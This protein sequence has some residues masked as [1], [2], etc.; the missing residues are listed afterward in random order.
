MDVPRLFRSEGHSQGSRS[1]QIILPAKYARGL[2]SIGP[3]IFSNAP[4][5]EQTDLWRP[6]NT[7]ERSRAQQLQ[8]VV[9]ELDKAVRQWEASPD[10]ATDVEQV[11][12]RFYA[13]RD[14]EATSAFD[15]PDE[16]RGGSQ[17][18]GGSFTI[19][20]GSSQRSWE[21][22]S[23]Q[24]ITQ[25][26]SS[27][28]A[29]QTD[30]IVSDP[31]PALSI[32]H[33]LETLSQQSSAYDEGLKRR[34]VL[35]FRSSSSLPPRQTQPKKEHVYLVDEDHQE[36]MIKFEGI[37]E[38]EIRVAIRE[39]QIA[40]MQANLDANRADFTTMKDNMSKDMAQAIERANH[41]EEFLVL[42]VGGTPAAY[43]EAN[44][45]PLWTL[46]KRS[47]FFACSPCTKQCCHS[48]AAKLGC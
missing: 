39:A 22:P 6:E 44:A 13:L 10:A 3:A 42:D 47:G 41:I 29:Q 31:S 38:R 16:S 18:V 45:H 35:D 2:E 17:E 43:E 27:S 34:D 40:A 36:A 14:V 9:K 4:S 46:F 21:M 19:L 25:G 33:S 20:E 23:Q 24:N 11:L 5:E 1:D 30:D 7:R 37:Q 28:S 12:Q 8:F 32:Q 48:T 26:R 15:V